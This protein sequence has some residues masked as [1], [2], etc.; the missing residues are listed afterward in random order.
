M[1]VYGTA[2]GL[3]RAPA[4]ASARHFLRH[5]GEML[6]AMFVGMALFGAL[7]SGILV[8]AGTTYDEA[9]NTAPELIALVL[10]FNMTVPMVLW[11]RHRGHSAA[12]VAEM[13]G[14][15]LAVGATAVALLWFSAIESTAICGVECALMVPAMIAVMLLRRSEYARPGQAREAAG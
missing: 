7:F 4:I 12:C 5:L 1:A 8:A 15:M 6:L 10:I 14:A 11:M 3:T 13:A 2:R 9:L